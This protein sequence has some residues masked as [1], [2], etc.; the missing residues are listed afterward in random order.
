M[1]SQLISKEIISNKAYAKLEQE[2]EKT[3]ALIHS[4]RNNNKF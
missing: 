2:V 4:I 1:G 3:L